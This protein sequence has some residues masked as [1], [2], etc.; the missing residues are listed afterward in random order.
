MIRQKANIS[1]AALSK[2]AG[3]SKPEVDNALKLAYILNT[4]VEYLWETYW[5][6]GIIKKKKALIIGLQTKIL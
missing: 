1:P 5:M 2:L 6:I 3:E 4:T